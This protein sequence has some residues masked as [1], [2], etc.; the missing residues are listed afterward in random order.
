M[1]QNELKKIVVR[2]DPKDNVLVALTDLEKG[3]IVVFENESFE[4]QDLIKAKHKFYMSDF[5][6]GDEIFMY[7]VL[8]GKVQ[9]NVAKGLESSVS[10]GETSIAVLGKAE[11]FSNSSLIMPSPASCSCTFWTLRPRYYLLPILHLH[12]DVASYA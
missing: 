7:G 9:T 10:G 8:V 11:G 1:S 6:L 12:D 3:K 4:M 5:Q 2:L